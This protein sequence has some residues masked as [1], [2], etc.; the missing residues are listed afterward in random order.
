MGILRQPPDV[1]RWYLNRSLPCHLWRTKRQGNKG[2][3]KGIHH[4][5]NMSSSSNSARTRRWSDRAGQTEGEHHYFRSRTR[6]GNP[7]WVFPGNRR[8]STLARRS[9]PLGLRSEE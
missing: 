4:A 3:R 2:N 6:E 9:A 8:H 5:T 1:T 7:S